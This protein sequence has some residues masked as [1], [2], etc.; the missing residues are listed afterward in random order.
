MKRKR[1]KKQALNSL[2]YNL[3]LIEQDI[4]ML[5]RVLKEKGCL[6]SE[7][8]DHWIEGCREGMALALDLV[9]SRIE[10]VAI[11]GMFEGH[12]IR[13]RY[14][15]GAERTITDDSLLVPFQR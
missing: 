3:S 2:A 10:D 7:F 13:V 1:G 9:E 5:N 6:R 8:E 12:P 14:K 4:E 15:I 11:R